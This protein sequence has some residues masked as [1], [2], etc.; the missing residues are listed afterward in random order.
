MVLSQI[1][2]PCRESKHQTDFLFV[3]VFSLAIHSIFFLTS[4]STEWKGWRKELN[5][6]RKFQRLILRLIYSI[7]GGRHG[8][9]KHLLRFSMILPYMDLLNS[10]THLWSVAVS[11]WKMKMRIS[12]RRKQLPQS[13]PEVPSVPTDPSSSDSQ[14]AVLCLSFSSP[15]VTG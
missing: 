2:L 10:Y 9:S 11:I 8:R 6:K 15:T 5:F 12:Q 7:M 3:L 4:R 1:L 14:N 13:C